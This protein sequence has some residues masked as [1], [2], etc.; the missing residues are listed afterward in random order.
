M[1]RRHEQESDF[2]RGRKCNGARPMPAVLSFAAPAPAAFVYFQT[3]VAEDKT[4][5]IAKYLA[6]MTVLLMPC[7]GSAAEWTAQQS[8]KEV[9]YDGTADRLWFI[10]F[11]KWGASA[12]PDAT[13][14]VVHSTVEGRKQLL[15][16]G[17]AA[18]MAGKRV[19]FWGSCDASIPDRFNATL[20]RVTD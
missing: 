18:Q 3:D 7:V 2:E 4:M 20:I 15:T 11:A 16:L 6:L 13:W 1:T 8:I 9:Q 19:S 10:G 17:T 12:C 5:R 14:V